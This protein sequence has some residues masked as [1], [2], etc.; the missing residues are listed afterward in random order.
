[1]N[2]SRINSNFTMKHNPQIYLNNDEYN[3]P[4]CEMW[5]FKPLG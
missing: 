3:N 4:K 2:Q 5:M 1:M